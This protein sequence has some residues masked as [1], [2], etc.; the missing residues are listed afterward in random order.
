[1]GAGRKLAAAAGLSLAASSAIGLLGETLMPKP[2]RYVMVRGRR[3]AINER[4]R[5]PAVVLL[6]GLGG[7]ARNFYRLPPLLQ[8]F[9]CIAIDRAGAGFSDP[10]PPGLNGLHAHADTV[11]RVIETLGIK[12]A[13]IVGHS[14]GGAVG[15]RLALD[16]PDLIAGF[17]GLAA[18][19]G[20]Q[21]PE[22]VSLSAALGRIAP[23]REAGVRLLGP[24]LLP[25][26]LPYIGWAAFS[27]AV[28]PP[29]FPLKGGVALAA[30]PRAMAGVMRD[31]QIIAH[32]AAPLRAALPRLDMP[33]TLVHGTQDK[34][35]PYR[36]H[37][38]PGALAIPGAQLWQTDGGHMVPVI[39]SHLAAAAI[40]E[41]AARAGLV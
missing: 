26:M 19:T 17:V 14:L 30:H 21:L 16:R 38:I 7:Q 37:A 28:M 1:M 25:A 34:V 24:A 3:I 12:R 9:R 40:R 27:P 6:H 23:L 29:E 36:L 11:A 39:E 2:S 31:V 41:T 22:L 33:V 15:L 13:L 20:P 4:G 18:M 10:A 8:G 5:G 32:D 35:L